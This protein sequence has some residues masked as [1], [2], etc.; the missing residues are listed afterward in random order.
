MVRTSSLW[1]T[2]WEESCTSGFHGRGDDPPLPVPIS[3]GDP[4]RDPSFFLLILLVIFNR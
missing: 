2:K 3:R 1:E 4:H